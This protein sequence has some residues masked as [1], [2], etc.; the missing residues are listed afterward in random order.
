MH[1]YTHCD[2]VSALAGRGKMGALRIV[3]NH[4]S[5]QEMFDLLG[6]EWVLSDHLFQKLQ[7]FTC[8]V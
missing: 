6:V 4:K 2:T 3:K 7:D 5:F 8:Q 1:A